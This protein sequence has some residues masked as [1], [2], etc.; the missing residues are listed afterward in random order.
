MRG[1]SVASRPNPTIR[2][3]TQVTPTAARPPD[4]AA[5]FVWERTPWGWMLTC[6]P[7]ARLGR[8]GFTARDLD[9]GRGVAP[10]AAWAA[11]AD[12]LGVPARSL[13]R[14]DQ[15]HGCRAL[16]VDASAWPAGDPL[17]SADAAITIRTDVALAVKAADCV[18]ILLA[19]PAGAVAAVHAGW[20]G[21]AQ[22]IA[23]RS[24]ADLAAAVG[25][26][27]RDIV[28]AIG[29]SIGPCCYEVGPEVRETFHVAG[30][31]E[32][33][34]D[35]WFLPT[36]PMG[37]RRGAPSAAHSS[38]PIQRAVG[39]VPEWNGRH[40]SN[41]SARA[42]HVLDMWRSN[43]DQLVAAGVDPANVHVAGLC[44]ATHN[45]WFWSYRREGPN[46]GR[47]L[48]VVRRA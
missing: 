1:T 3:T 19:H 28:A 45:D 18:P 32:A 36:E 24:T 30:F 4:P 43:R 44:T 23:G 7:L 31:A 5:P 2:M 10:D 26:S 34:L 38:P 15:V 42:T 35:R 22:G 33:D 39:A 20:R 47:M 41:E 9:P 48:A 17:P 25:G 6:P 12:W 13:W 40:P 21:T 37:G 11:V 16:R 14:L 46:A 27:P 29:P 8:H